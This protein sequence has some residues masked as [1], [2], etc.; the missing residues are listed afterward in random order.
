MRTGERFADMVA[1]EDDDAF[2]AP[3]QL[4]SWMG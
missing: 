2:T 3:L 1:G 4:G